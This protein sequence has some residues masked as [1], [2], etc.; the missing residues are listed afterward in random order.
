M[1]KVR[2]KDMRPMPFFAT[3]AVVFCMQIGIPAA[4]GPAA[5]QEGSR[6][7]PARQDIVRLTVRVIDARSEEGLLGA[8]VELSGL[9]ERFVTGVDGRA[10]M[11]VPRGSYT[12][13]VR[14]G[15]YEVLSG[16]LDVF[17]PGEF[18]L[19]LQRVGTMDATATATLEVRVVDHESGEGVG[20]ARVSILE[21]P[22]GVT[23]AWG[24]AEFSGLDML[25][26]EVTVE[27]GGYAK[28]TAP[29]ALHP[30]RTALVRVAMTAA[31]DAPRPVEVVVR[32]RAMD[33]IYGASRVWRR[34]R[35]EAL[36]T[37][38]MLDELAVDRLSDAL[39]TL[40]GFRVE[41]PRPDEAWLVAPRQCRLAVEV[42]GVGRRRERN[43]VDVI[44]VYQVERVE[45]H[46]LKS[47]GC[48][49]VSIWTR[50]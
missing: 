34:G 44:P 8:V 9:V 37:R 46:V 24:F 42:D 45:I 29:V 48:G 25:V 26:A 1:M 39:A 19:S 49:V 12:L 18:T 16:D 47:R 43:N 6:E 20:E 41:R 50:G 13:T 5:A 40:R 31:D 4:G 35:R 33:G 3:A 21:G 10:G 2:A 36:F 14:R 23:D 7:T 15:L 27:A 38:G 32:T 28:R 22:G 30:F 11:E 17:E